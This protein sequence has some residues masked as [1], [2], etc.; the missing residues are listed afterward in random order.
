MLAAAQRILSE[1]GIQTDVPTFVMLFGLA[2][3]RLA[4][5]IALTPF[6]GGRSA[7]GRIKIGLA[8]V[9]TVLLYRSVTPA[10]I[11]GDMNAV[12]F[13]CLLIKEAVIGATLGFLTQI[14]FSS[15]QMAGA[16]IDY[17]R[18]MSQ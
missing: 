7:S 4:A 9:I 3:T 1:L 5:A 11:V 18:G 13:L 8:V 10:S 17:G 2:L 14:V 12:R 16:M 6:L 15:V